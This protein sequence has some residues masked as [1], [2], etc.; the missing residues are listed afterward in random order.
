MVVWRDRELRRR[1]ATADPR[2]AR[3]R[4]RSGPAVVRVRNGPGSLVVL[5]ID[6][7]SA[8]AL[9]ARERVALVWNSGERRCCVLPRSEV[10]ACWAIDTRNIGSGGE[11]SP[12]RTTSTWC[13]CSESVPS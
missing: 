3:A 12:L 10:V 5:D 2:R 13:C 1:E 6:Y 9:D 7:A 11:R 4:V 8:R